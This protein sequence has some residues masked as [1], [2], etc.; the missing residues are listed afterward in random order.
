[1]QSQLLPLRTWKGEQSPW[2]ANIGL[3]L[4][5][6]PYIRQP[7][8]VCRLVPCKYVAVRIAQA[9]RVAAH[10]VR[11]LA[12][13]SVQSSDDLTCCPDQCY[14]GL[15]KD[16]CDGF[17]CNAD[18]YCCKSS[19]SG[20]CKRKKSKKVSSGAIIA[21]IVFAVV[22]GVIFLALCLQRSRQYTARA[23]QQQP[24]TPNYRPT[25]SFTL[26]ARQPAAVSTGNN[27]AS[28]PTMTGVNASYAQ[29]SQLSGE[30]E[31][32]QSAGSGMPLTISPTEVPVQEYRPTDR[33]GTVSGTVGD[34]DGALTTTNGDVFDEP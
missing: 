30:I 13:L 20:C 23:S 17:A 3:Y 8:L 34:S 16:C 29:V 22:V 19:S 9:R 15:Y 10:R 5:R 18:N 21:G 12:V 2:V 14:G 26:K 27:A 33:T 24:S 6:G 1:M 25:L 11:I 28:A 7:S 32:Q 31:M 4:T